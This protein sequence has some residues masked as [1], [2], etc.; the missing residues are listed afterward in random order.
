MIKGENSILRGDFKI[1]EFWAEIL[2]RRYETLCTKFLEKNRRFGFLAEKDPNSKKKNQLNWSLD[3]GDIVDLKSDPF[4][5]NFMMAGKWKQIGVLAKNL[6]VIEVQDAFKALR[7]KEKVR[8]LVVERE[9]TL[10]LNM[11]CQMKS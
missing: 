6:Y 10:P 5:E 3:E 2:K 1:F 8:Y 7:N 4:P 9:G 11:R